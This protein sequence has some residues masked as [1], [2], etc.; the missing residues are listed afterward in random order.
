MEHR[1]ICAG[2]GGQGI[3]L[4]GQLLAHAALAEGFETVRLP[5]YGP[6]TRGG[7]ANCSVIISPGHI[8]SPIVSGDAT[9]VLVMNEPSLARFE[10]DLRP[11]G[12]LVINSSLVKQLPAR[13]DLVV[14]AVPATELAI[15]AGAPQVANVVMLGALLAAVPLFPESL[16]L[17][18]IH[19]RLGE[20]KAHLLEVNGK[21]L[22]LGFEAIRGR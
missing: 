7:T 6:E 16:L 3:M 15:E 10:A 2:F 21:A 19:R 14:H 1:I 20:S 22:R 9:A 4:M 8:D 18:M 5:T 11:G 12:T 13:R 17:E